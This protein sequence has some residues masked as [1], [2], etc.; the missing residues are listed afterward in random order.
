LVDGLGLAR[1]FGH[2]VVYHGVVNGCTSTSLGL[3]L[4]ETRWIP[5]LVGGMALVRVSVL[6]RKAWQRLP[7][8]GI[9]SSPSSPRP[10]GV[11]SVFGERVEVCFR[12]ISLVLVSIPSGQSFSSSATVEALVQWLF[13]AL[14]R[15]LPLL[16]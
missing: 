1:Y 16:Q 8:D 6:F 15:R 3:R 2:V 5:V 9:K 12:Q 10:D 13:G 4:L 7:Q 14:A 11:S